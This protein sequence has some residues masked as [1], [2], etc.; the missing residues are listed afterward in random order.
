MQLWRPCPRPPPCGARALVWPPVRHSLAA[1]FPVSQVE[2]PTFMAEPGKSH[3]TGP[4]GAWGHPGRSALV[5]GVG[6][7]CRSM[8]RGGAGM[9][10]WTGLRETE[11][12]P[13]PPG[14]PGY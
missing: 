3:K 10:A 7:A 5:Q 13:Q 9:S 12:R 4:H 1:G 8:G 11:R 2:L 6:R 14:A